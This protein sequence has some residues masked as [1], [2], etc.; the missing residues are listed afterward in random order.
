[1]NKSDSNLRLLEC[2][3]SIIQIHLTR[4]TVMCIA[5]DIIDSLYDMLV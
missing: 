4:G 3:F 2:T 5:E 1:M